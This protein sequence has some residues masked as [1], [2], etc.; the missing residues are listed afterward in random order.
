[1][2]RLLIAIMIKSEGTNVN[3]GEIMTG[4]LNV[5]EIMNATTSCLIAP[6]MSALTAAIRYE[7]TNERMTRYK[8]GK[9]NMFMDVS[10]KKG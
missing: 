4:V 10:Q 2:L 8:R 5:T 1:M 6:E 3:M 7:W 9:W